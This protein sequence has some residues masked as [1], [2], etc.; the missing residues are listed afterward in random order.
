MINKN[1]QVLS[2]AALTGIALLG[3]SAMVQAA[4]LDEVK[5]RGQV[6]CGV[7]DGLAG[8]SSPDSKG[9]WQGID[10]EVCK[11]VAAAVL[12]DQNKVAFAPLTAKERFTALQSGEVDV[13]S[14]NT[15]WTASRDNSMGLNFAGVNFYDGQG[16]LVKKSLGVSSARELD[17]ASICVNSGTTTELNLADYF[18]AQDMQYKAVAFDE[19]S[20]TAQG[21]D[22]GRCDALTSDSSQLAALRLQLKEPDSAVILPERISKEPLGPVVAQGDD[23]WFDVVK[24]TLF[25]MLDAEELGVT[26]SNVDDMRDNPPNPNVARLLGKDGNYGEQMGLSNAWAYNIIKQVGNYGE[27]YDRTVG[28]DS[29]LD[30]PRGINALW[31]NGGIQYA[32]PI[33]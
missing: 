24:W 31:N 20:Q 3:A 15:T 27:V 28:K 9:K 32:P 16:F 29:P 26:S 1:N 11:A 6:R 14:R 33:R 4:T 23:Q 22:S 13:L 2:F 7:S 12:D 25:A 8:F 30:I 10:V 17:G 19:M 5:D 18:R 21:F